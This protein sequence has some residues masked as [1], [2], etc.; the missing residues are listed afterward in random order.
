MTA[1]A[2][3]VIIEN[4]AGRIHTPESFGRTIIAGVLKSAAKNGR[5]ADRDGNIS[6]PAGKF[7]IKNIPQTVRE[8]PMTVELC[9]EDEEAGMSVCIYV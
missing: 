6:V 9:W 5:K 2:E 8:D 1:I 3:K 4:I 7:T